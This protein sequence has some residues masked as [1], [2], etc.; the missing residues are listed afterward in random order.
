[1]AIQTQTDSSTLRNNCRADQGSAC[2]YIRVVIADQSGSVVA[3]LSWTS[4]C[5]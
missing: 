2:V 4:E 1:M 3:S 5:K